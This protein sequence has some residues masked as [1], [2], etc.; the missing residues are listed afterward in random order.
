MRD[1][2]LDAF[3][4][5]VSLRHRSETNLAWQLSVQR[6]ALCVAC[7][8]QRNARRSLCPKIYKPPQTEMGLQNGIP[9]LAQTGVK[10]VS[11]STRSTIFE[12]RRRGNGD[13]SGRPFISNPRE[14]RR[15]K[16]AIE[17]L[18]LSSFFDTR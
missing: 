12:M 9:Y 16:G 3:D 10:N 2:L 8:Q 6:V 15:L 14:S 17:A 4:N 7:L 1:T 11:G 13:K 5:T 18:G